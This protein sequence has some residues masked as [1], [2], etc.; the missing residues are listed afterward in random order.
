[1]SGELIGL[2]GGLFFPLLL[3]PDLVVLLLCTF[4]TWMILRDGD[5]LTTCGKGSALL[6]RDL[7]PP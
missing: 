4:G 1:M 3:H 6:S 7:F 5:D 2:R